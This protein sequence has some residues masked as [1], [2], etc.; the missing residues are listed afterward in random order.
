MISDLGNAIH[1][2]LISFSLTIA[3]LVFFLNSPVSSFVLDK[4]N[5]RSLHTNHVPRIGG[6]ALVLGVV[7]AWVVAGI[8]SKWILFVLCLMSV[9]LVDD[10]RGLSVRWRLLAQMAVSA[11]FMWFYLPNLAWWLVPVALFGLVWMTNLYNFMD[12]SDGLAG[13]MAVFGFGAFAVAAYSAQN[14]QLAQMCC[15][16]VASSLAFLI[17]NFYPAKIF[18]GDAGSIPLG[19]LAGAIGLFGWQQGVWPLW[20]PVLVFSPFIVDA[21]MTLLKRAM[22]GE[23]VWQAHKAHYYQR[24]VQMGWGHKKTALAEYV[25][26]L[27]ACSSAILVLKAPTFWLY[28][29]LLLWV[30]IFLWLMFLV[31]KHWKLHL[32]SP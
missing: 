28:A 12:G 2:I 13:G 9:S 30:F 14:M 18:M 23:K 29:L 24:L 8:E 21:T 5:A 1:T 27:L 7:T 4:P 26:M 19:F 15:A 6:L 20:F 32:P 22:N 3:S 25:L 10:L 31:D 17:F 16:I 11:C